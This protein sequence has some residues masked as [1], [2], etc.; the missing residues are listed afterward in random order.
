MKTG[1]ILYLIPLIFLIACENDNTPEI[2]QLDFYDYVMQI[3]TS[4]RC[5][6][7]SFLR[8]RREM[9]VMKLEWQ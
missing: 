8:E 4:R 3:N 1:N 2:R 7:R 6:P 5:S 9:L